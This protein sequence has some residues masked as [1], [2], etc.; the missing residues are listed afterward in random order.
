MYEHDISG[1]CGDGPINLRKEILGEQAFKHDDDVVE[2]VTCELKSSPIILNI[3]E[4]SA[5]MS[6]L[7]D[8]LPRSPFANT[9]NRSSENP[10]NNAL[11]NDNEP[12]DLRDKDENV[13]EMSSSVGGGK[14]DLH[15]IDSNGMCNTPTSDTLFKGWSHNDVIDL[16]DDDSDVAYSAPTPLKRVYQKAELCVI[17]LIED[18]PKVTAPDVSKEAPSAIAQEIKESIEI[19]EIE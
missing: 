14:S 13:A 16:M 2:V 4:S 8:S 19:I 7:T 3:E 1:Q 18:D 15:N 12:V 17:D 11:W 6:S 9:P 5:S 10:V